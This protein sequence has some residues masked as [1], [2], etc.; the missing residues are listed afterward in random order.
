[1]RLAQLLR[2]AQNALG[3]VI[4]EMDE[5]GVLHLGPLDDR[6]HQRRLPPGRDLL[7]AEVDL[8]DRLGLRERQRRRREERDGDEL[9]HQSSP[10]DCR[11]F[12]LNS[13]RILMRF[14][15][16]TFL[17]DSTYSPSGLVRSPWMVSSSK[18]MTVFF[19]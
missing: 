5:P 16:R 12:S 6:L 4:A 10:T 1:M 11:T 2:R 15:W 17:R 19:S 3:E 8:C 9:L 14:E 13:S 18:L 7:L